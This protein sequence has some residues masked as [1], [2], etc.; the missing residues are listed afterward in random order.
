MYLGGRG[1]SLFKFLFQQFL[2]EIMSNTSKGL[3]QDIL[4][5][6]RLKLDPPSE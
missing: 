1:R 6:S 2:M 3:S 4:S 5:L